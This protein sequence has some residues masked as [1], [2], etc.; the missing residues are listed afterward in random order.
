MASKIAKSTGT[1]ILWVFD[2]GDQRKSLGLF[3]SQYLIEESLSGVRQRF[4]GLVRGEPFSR[5]GSESSDDFLARSFDEP[6]LLCQGF[7][8]LSD[9]FFDLTM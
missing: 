8:K 2:V 4:R 9:T 1:S 5:T 3:I 7:D 6:S